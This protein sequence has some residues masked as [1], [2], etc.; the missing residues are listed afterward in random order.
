VEIKV[1]FTCHVFT[2]DIDNAGPRPELYT[3]KRETRAFDEEPYNWS[4][5][6]KGMTELEKRKCYFARREQ[7]VTFEE[8][9]VRLDCEYRIFFTVRR[10]DS[11]TVELLVQSACLGRKELRPRGQSK[12]PIGFRAIVRNVMLQRA[13]FE[14]R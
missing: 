12:Q 10:K 6:L 14:A 8:A 7:F 4:F 11:S 13:L 2:C 1:G 9:G 5:R 3:D